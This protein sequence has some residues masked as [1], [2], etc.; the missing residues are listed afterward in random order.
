MFGRVLCAVGRHSWVQRTNPEA[1]GR[2]AVYYAC[3]RCGVD[4][5]DVSPSFDNSAS[6]RLKRD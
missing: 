2:G 4:R 6:S 5:L 1:G 3:R